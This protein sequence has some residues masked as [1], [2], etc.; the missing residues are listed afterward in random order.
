MQPNNALEYHP[1]AVLFPPPE[2]PLRGQREG[3]FFHCCCENHCYTPV[4]AFC[5]DELVAPYLS[6][7][8]SGGKKHSG[9][10]LKR[11]IRRLRESW[12]DVKIAIRGDSSFCPNRA[13]SPPPWPGAPPRGECTRARNTGQVVRGRPRSTAI[14]DSIETSTRGETVTADRKST[15]MTS[16]LTELDQPR[17]LI[18]V[19]HFHR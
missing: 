2:D 3:W 7:S 8:K 18:A 4:Y 17:A 10:L 15:R 6:P 5:A 16:P 19:P 14:P 9:A 11:L 12:P 1:L 13:R